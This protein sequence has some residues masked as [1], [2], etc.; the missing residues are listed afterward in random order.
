MI[1]NLEIA[2]YEFDENKL[3]ILNIKWLRDNATL[4]RKE[5]LDWQNNYSVIE[6]DFLSDW[7]TAE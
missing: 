5:R 6:Q 3:H 4:I 1:C 7:E 2:H